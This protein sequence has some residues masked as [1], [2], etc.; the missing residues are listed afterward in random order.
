MLLLKFKQIIKQQHEFKK[1]DRI[2]VGVSGGVDSLCLLDMLWKLSEE[3]EWTLFAAHLNH[4]FRGEES[5]EDALYVG[6]FCAERDIP[7][8][9]GEINVPQLILETQGNPQSV[10][11]DARYSF[12]RQV[13][14]RRDTSKLALAHHAND[15]A[16]TVLMRILRGTG[17][18]GLAGIHRQREDI[19]FTIV[20]PLLSIY[21]EE[22]EAYCLQEGIIPRLD[23]SNL[24]K[25]Y[26]RNFI[27]LEVIPWLEERV[28]PSLQDSL[29]QLSDIAFFENDYIEEKAKDSLNQ[30]IKS[31]E[32]NKIIIKGKL[33]LDYHVALQRRMIKLIFN[34]LIKYHVN[35]GFVHINQVCEWIKEGRT[36]SQLELPHGVRAGKE[37]DD[38]I[39][40]LESFNWMQ[41]SSYSYILKVPGRTY[42]KEI[43]AWISVHIGDPQ[44]AIPSSHNTETAVFDF[45]EI[46]GE[47]TLR[48]RCNGDRMSILGMD[49]SKKVKDILI[50]QK[51][52]QRVRDK[53]PILSDD[54]GILWIPGV[55][56]SNRAKKSIHT[57][58]IITIHLEKMAEY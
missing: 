35:V 42:I 44:S 38:V 19:P 56:R 17:I 16:E 32:E 12:F 10:A 9:V 49:G 8:E 47:L 20:R 50:D 48:S 5:K 29:N 34:Y 51:V 31:K 43:N 46:V 58:K 39:F 18:E 25:S 37:Y 33:F 45:D 27:R 2:L 54:K 22:L 30:I 23:S 15:Q 26:H 1:G 6:R 52:P 24:K 36:S 28:N 57:K 7:C 3:Q 41:G 55:K 13:A 11:R 14:G 21:K 4:Q 53:I 40:T